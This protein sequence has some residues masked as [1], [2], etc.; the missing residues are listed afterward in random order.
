[1]TLRIYPADRLAEAGAIA[2]RLARLG[3]RPGAP[4]RVPPCVVAI[5]A[6]SYRRCPACG[7]HSRG[8][9]TFHHPRTAAY[10]AVAQC[11]NRN[12]RFVEEV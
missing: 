11:V 6:S 5:D 8:L 9:R 2:E 1:M 12:C 4:A 3:F 7:R 10:R